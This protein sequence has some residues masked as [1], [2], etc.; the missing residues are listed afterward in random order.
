MAYEFCNHLAG[1]DYTEREERGTEVYHG[2]RMHMTHFANFHRNQVMEAWGVDGA[3][4]FTTNQTRLW[5]TSCVARMIVG[6]DWG[7][8]C[9]GSDLVIGGD[10]T[11]LGIS[12]K[13]VSQLPDV[14]TPPNG[15]RAPMLNWR[16]NDRCAVPSNWNP[17]VT[18]IPNYRSYFRTRR[19]AVRDHLILCSSIHN[20]KMKGKKNNKVFHVELAAVRQEVLHDDN[21]HELWPAEVFNQLVYFFDSSKWHDSVASIEE[22]DGLCDVLLSAVAAVTLTTVLPSASTRVVVDTFNLNPDTLE[23][24]GIAMDRFVPMWRSSRQSLMDHGGG[25]LVTCHTNV[26]ML[27]CCGL[28]GIAYAIIATVQGRLK[29]GLLPTDGFVRLLSYLGEAHTHTQTI[30]RHVTRLTQLAGPARCMHI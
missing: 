24:L 17:A 27:T 3:G 4:F 1:Q 30:R 12:R 15:V 19:R 28:S 21:G 7:P 11:E 9:E 2:I 23:P 13:H 26:H 29:R 18:S 14:H 16:V 20:P 8:C 22:R 6:L 10:G 5:V 25:L